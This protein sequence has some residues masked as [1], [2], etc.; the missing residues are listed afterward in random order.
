MN[1]RPLSFAP[2]RRAENRQICWSGKEDSNLRPLPPEGCYPSVSAH[3]PVHFAYRR[4]SSGGPCSLL[5]HG[6][7]FNLILQPLS[8]RKRKSRRTVAPSR[9]F[10]PLASTCALPFGR[11]FGLP[12]AGAA[13]RVSILPTPFDRRDLPTVR[14]T[15]RRTVRPLTRRHYY[16]RHR[17]RIPR[18]G[19]LP[20]LSPGQSA[21]QLEPRKLAP[22]GQRDTYLQKLTF[23]HVCARI[24]P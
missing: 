10:T 6:R 2:M 24:L 22:Y 9:R 20:G 15:I 17:P 1:L 5:V 19:Q 11:L 3:F 14:T 13:Q 4:L 21:G 18:F 23:G 12:R 16:R 8:V 7:R